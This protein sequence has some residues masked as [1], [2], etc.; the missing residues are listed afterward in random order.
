MLLYRGAFSRS[1]RRQLSAPTDCQ[2]LA[3]DENY[4]IRWENVP[5]MS[6]LGLYYAR[7]LADCIFLAQQLLT[8][9]VVPTLSFS[10]K[11]L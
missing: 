5:M 1:Q 9:H 7:S 6:I 2:H 4:P 3:S 10:K 8:E 11:N